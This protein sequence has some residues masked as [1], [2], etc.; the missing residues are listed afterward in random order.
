MTL[1]ELYQ[2]I[3]GD[4]DAAMRTLRIEKLL[5]KHIRKLPQNGL[6]E[7]LF[8]AG[9]TMNPTELFETSHAL[10][11]VCGNLGLTA[12]Y[13][14]ASEIS[15]QFRPGKPRTM[16]DAEVQEKLGEIEALYRSCVDGI[17][18]YAAE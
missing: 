11:G 14:A 18:K 2:S 3:G 6:A 16:T 17:E 15:E 10:K 12:L 8:A 9:K 7:A 5:D 1:Q 4:Y 13:E